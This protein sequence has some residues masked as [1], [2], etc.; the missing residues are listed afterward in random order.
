M[1]SKLFIIWEERQAEK[2]QLYV[3]LYDAD[4]VLKKFSLDE[5]QKLGA[6]NDIFLVLPA[7]SCTIHRLHL[8]NVNDKDLSLAVA[9]ILEDKILG[10]FVDFFSYIEKM[11]SE[12]YLVFLWKKNI[13]THIQ[14]FFEKHQIHYTAITLDWFALKSRE[15]FLMADG[16]AFVYSDE[17]Q[18]Y[19]NRS[20]FKHWFQNY[21]F[22]A[23]TMYASQLYPEYVGVQEVHESFWVWMAKRLNEMPIKDIFAKPKR[24]DINRLIEPKRL[25]AHLP[26]LFCSSL[27]GVLGVFLMV[28]AS[29]YMLIHKNQQKLQDIISMSDD[30]IDLHLNRYLDK[31]KQKSQFWSCWAAVQ[32]AKSNRL[33]IDNIQYQQAKMK[34]QLTLTDMQSYQQFKRQLIRAHVKIINSQL[35]TDA[36]SIRLMLEIGV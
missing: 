8:P 11:S 27:V 13:L 10:N 9:A 33:S 36:N 26:K 30:N 3:V 7:S 34:L 16:S 28:Y 20:V 24:F 6:D 2:E 19:L 22:D 23:V 15:I 14:T 18:G 31:Q 12:D 29:N 25:W 17:V 21:S 4:W 5:L 32:A 1:R 35:Q